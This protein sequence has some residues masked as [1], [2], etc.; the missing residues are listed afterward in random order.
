ME[1]FRKELFQKS[2]RQSKRPH[3]LPIEKPSLRGLGHRFNTATVLPWS[4]HVHITPAEENPCGALGVDEYKT[5]H[6][7]LTAFG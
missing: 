7:H 3:C 2:S 1:I 6:A 4:S 5:Q